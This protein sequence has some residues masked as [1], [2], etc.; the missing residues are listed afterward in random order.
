[1]NKQMRE[2]AKQAEAWVCETE[3]GS[4]DDTDLFH[5]LAMAKFAELIVKEC[6]NRATWAQDTSAADIGGEVLK[7]FGVAE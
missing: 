4:M 2:L 1:M 3:P 5:E 6:A 7:H